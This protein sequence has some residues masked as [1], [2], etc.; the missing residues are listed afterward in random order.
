MNHLASYL[1]TKFKLLPEI[2][3]ISQQMVGFKSVGSVILEVTLLIEL[4]VTIV[5]EFIFTA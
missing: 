4:L 1:A 3:P 5:A 2:R